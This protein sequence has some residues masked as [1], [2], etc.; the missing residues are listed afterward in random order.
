MTPTLDTW[1]L[2]GHAGDY[3][4]PDG[5]KQSILLAETGGLDGLSEKELAIRG[6]SPTALRQ[7]LRA[8]CVNRQYVEVGTL[9]A[10]TL[11]PAAC[12]KGS[13]ALGII[14]DDPQHGDVAGRLRKRLARYGDRISVALAIGRTDMTLF[15]LPDKLADVVLLK[16]RKQREAV[17]RR[18][19]LAIPLLRAQ[20]AILVTNWQSEIVRRATAGAIRRAKADVLWSTERLAPKYPMWGNGLGVF[21][22]RPRR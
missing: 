3:L 16:W 6:S 1:R 20:G 4:D 14:D 10:D 18:T 9:S 15:N 17:S 11:I 21:F 22:V 2:N 8:I 5:I 13:S 12:G 19:T 7:L